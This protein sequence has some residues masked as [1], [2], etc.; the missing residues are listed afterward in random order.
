[1]NKRQAK[2][3]AKKL[4]YKSY[5]N[6][7]LAK[8]R[9]LI[10]KYY[11][12]GQ[13]IYIVTSKKSTRRIRHIYLLDQV[14]PKAINNE[15]KVETIEFNCGNAAEQVEFDPY[16]QGAPCFMLKVP[17][18]IKQDSSLYRQYLDMYVKGLKEDDNG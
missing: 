17:S 15:P 11:K 4:G 18:F 5:E 14:Y 12:S 1:M 16:T 10:D 8:I 9:M 3:S 6:V 2:K 7:F 13:F